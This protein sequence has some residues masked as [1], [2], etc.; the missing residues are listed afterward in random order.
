MLTA[1]DSCNA[2]NRFSAVSSLTTTRTTIT[3]NPPH[4]F[5]CEVNS[6][7]LYCSPRIELALARRGWIPLI[8]CRRRVM[9]DIAPGVRCATAQ[10]TEKS[11]PWGRTRRQFMVAL[12]EMVR[13]AQAADE[14]GKCTGKS[15]MSRARF[16]VGYLIAVA[17][18][19]YIS[20]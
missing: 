19:F 14:S 17:W 20:L 1:R 15:E 2:Y 11:R 3:Y 12:R 10:P 7:K 16:I 8:R 5:R 13:G 4:C 9:V 6:N 18:D